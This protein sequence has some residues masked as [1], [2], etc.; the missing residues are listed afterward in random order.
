MNF[1]AVD[2]AVT[3]QV[4]RSCRPAGTGS[5]TWSEAPSAPSRAYFLPAATF[6]PKASLTVRTTCS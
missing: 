6:G 4:P 3:R 2:V 1:E 5:F